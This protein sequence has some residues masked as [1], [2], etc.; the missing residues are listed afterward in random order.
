M[1][2]IHK[3]ILQTNKKM[4]VNSKE[5]WAKDLNRY[6]R[7]GGGIYWMINIQKDT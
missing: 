6:F 7:G 1:F 5:K 2:E 4:R 3:E